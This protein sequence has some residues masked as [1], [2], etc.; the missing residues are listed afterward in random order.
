MSP[1]HSGPPIPPLVFWAR[2]VLLSSAL[3]AVQSP[4][5]PRIPLSPVNPFLV[6]PQQMERADP[7]TLF[8]VA[9][10]LLPGSPLSMFDSI[11][12]PTSGMIIVSPMSPGYLSPELSDPESTSADVLA[13]RWL[14]P[15]TPSCAPTSAPRVIQGCRD[16][17]KESVVSVLVMGQGK[18]RKNMFFWK[19]LAGRRWQIVTKK[20]KTDGKCM[21]SLVRDG[22]VRWDAGGQR[23]R[24]STGDAVHRRG[25]A[26]HVCWS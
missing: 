10:P 6:P 7:E 24:H 13:P 1:H 4:G 11:M 25:Q 18:Q 26:R 2:N 9:A 15:L 14:H 5:N 21:D 16:G 12:S 3:H 19:W 20:D 17:K 22:K 23:E 8:P